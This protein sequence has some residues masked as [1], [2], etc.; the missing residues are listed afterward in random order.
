LSSE[1][2]AALILGRLQGLRERNRHHQFED[3]CLAYVRARIDRNVLPATG[4]VSGGGDG[5][6]DFQSH[7]SS[8]LVAAC[9]TQ[10]KE[11]DR[12]VRS[13]VE[14]ATRQGAVVKSVYA[15]LAEGF[16]AGHRDAL[17]EELTEELGV[18]VH[19]ID[20]PALAQ[21]LAEDD[22]LGIAEEHLDLPLLRE[23]ALERQP[24][25]LGA[26]ATVDPCRAGAAGVPPDLALPFHVERDVDDELREAFEKGLSRCGVSLVIAEGEA[27]SGR[28]HACLTAL[29]AA[30][31]ELPVHRAGTAGELRTWLV[32]RH[33]EPAALVLDPLE[34]VLAEGGDTL[35]RNESGRDGWRPPLLLVGVGRPP[36]GGALDWSRPQADARIEVDAMLMPHELERADRDLT[37]AGIRD[38][39]ERVG[40]GPALVA[41]PALA[42]EYRRARGASGGSGA[43]RRLVEVLIGWHRI[44]M[45]EA[46]SEG[47][48]RDLHAALAPDWDAWEEAAGWALTRIGRG[49]SPA[50]VSG[51]DW[52][53]HPALV[54]L[55]L[56]RGWED[57]WLDDR[58]W[59][60]LR[61]WAGEEPGRLASLGSAASRLGDQARAANVLRAAIERGS[62][63]ARLNLA[64]LLLRKPRNGTEEAAAILVALRDD[65]AEDAPGDGVAAQA[66]ALTLRALGHLYL[67]RAPEAAAGAYREAVRWGDAD[68]MVSLAQLERQAGREDEGLR[69][70]HDAAR[71]GS[72]LAASSLLVD[73]GL[74]FGA[75]V[76][77]LDAAATEMLGVLLMQ[78]ERGE[79]AERAFAIAAA[80]GRLPA[81]AQLGGLLLEH[82]PDRAIEVLEPAVERGS[83]AATHYLGRA[84]RDTDVAR[85]RGLLRRAYEMGSASAGEELL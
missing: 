23:A 1:Q 40:L 42:A 27:C 76:D 77:Q 82:D 46:L 21:A 25:F 59:A 38:E 33:A 44:G 6:R 70:A 57:R 85:A 63:R 52:V 31:P 45:R 7:G 3:L 24:Q 64:L 10:L 22:L 72:A 39:V 68:S 51:G 28:T 30:A 18:E 20:G 15:F 19:I 32:H 8:G 71:D 66:L 26:A 48:L 29:A 36:S 11:L 61:A 83:R 4:P 73:F 58:P 47:A 50:R 79:E 16:Q 53:A 78:N 37:H 55:P 43:G 75:A 34:S 84:L 14:G 69:L 67:E 65:L 5:G 81:R 56:P 74:D 60:A 17:R 49:Q 41:A 80:A 12:K 35:I 54:E 62:R 9:T 13:D 2:R